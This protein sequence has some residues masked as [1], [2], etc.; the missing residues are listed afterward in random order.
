M[1]T[2][3]ELK[4]KAK[5]NLKKHYLIF[6]ALCLIAGFIGSEFNSSL[7][8]ITS[9]NEEADTADMSSSA[10][11]GPKLGITDVI[12]DV[13][14]GNL[15]EGNR[16]AS[17]LRADIVEQSKESGD[18]VFGRS[19]GVLSSLINSI[20]SGS[21][22][23]NIAMALQSIFRSHNTMLAILIVLGMLVFCGGWF[24]TINVYPVI[25]RRMF[26][27][28][29][30]YDNLHVH[31]SLFLLKIKRWIHAAATMLLSRIYL[32][33]WSFTIIGGIIKHYSYYMV[34]YIVAENPD[35][36][37]RAAIKLSRQMMKG[38]KL[39][40]FVH[41][42]TFIGWDLLGSITLGLVNILFTNPYKVAFFTEY[43][44][45]LR[46]LAKDDPIENSHLLNDD[47]LYVRAERKDLERVYSDVIAVTSQP[48]TSLN[49][50]KGIQRLF[51]DVFGVTFRSSKQEQA[52][53]RDQARRIRVAREIEA[54]D[55]KVYPTRLSPFPSSQ[56]REWIGSVHYIRHYSIWSII[57]I[58]F[59]LAFIGWLWEVS[60]HLITNGEFVN[61]GVLHGPWLPIYG[62]GSVLI[63]LLLNKLRKYPLLEFI[64]ATALC[65]CVEYFTAY[66]LEMTHNGQK[67]WDYT[68]YYLNLD[69]RICAEGLLT[70]GIGGML[71]VY[72]LAPILDNLIQKI[73]RNIL[74]PLCAALIIL[75]S[76][77]QLYSSEHPN[78]GKGITDYAFL[79]TYYLEI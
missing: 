42:L 8:F 57:M 36:P 54:L 10:I 43:Y 16:K 19:R 58:F 33:L 27:E 2:R 5:H 53:R 12:A 26:M 18:P 39:E 7:T 72:V 40:C 74:I 77:D 38:H 30:C 45:Q 22:L 14:S 24:L 67:W 55:G 9:T 28:G 6:A 31:R 11:I 64:S 25:S 21:L 1:Q 34:P 71:I 3:K 50:L 46:Q 20:T 65:G 49:E 35:I 56:K 4:Q 44:V 23:V 79:I 51:A 61:R 47:Y 73:S 13:F 41:T 66:Y 48:K 29:R 32:F 70:F 76:C 75:Y 62:T 52:Y 69:G 60:L 15:E 17:V 37:S 63:L 59:I 68:G 78:T